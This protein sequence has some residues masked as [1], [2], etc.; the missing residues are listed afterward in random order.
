VLIGRFFVTLCERSPLAIGPEVWGNTCVQL[1]DGLCGE[2]LTDVLSGEVIEV[3]HANGRRS[4][5][6]GGAFSTLPVAVLV[7]G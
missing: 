4:V 6:L 7:N 2:G 5:P 3:R 1:P